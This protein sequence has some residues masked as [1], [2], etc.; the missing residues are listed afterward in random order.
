MP[1][2]LI[3]SGHFCCTS[4]LTAPF[5]TLL[6]V[7]CKLSNKTLHLVLNHSDRLAETSLM[8]LT[9][10]HPAFLPGKTSFFLVTNYWK[11][12]IQFFFTC[13]LSSSWIE[14]SQEQF[15]GSAYYEK[16]IKCSLSLNIM[17]K[18]I[19][20]VYKESLLVQL[21]FMHLRIRCLH[22]YFCAYPVSKNWWL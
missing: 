15:H 1:I 4:S 19:T 17:C 18:H 3:W 6:W 7:T 2:L 5:P 8:T 14:D 12:W 10:D 20:Q 16:K 21:Y 22:G 9:Q 11:F 13:T